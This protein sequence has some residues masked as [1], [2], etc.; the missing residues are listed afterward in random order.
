MKRKR[1]SQLLGLVLT[2]SMVF[3]MVGCG[4]QNKANNSEDASVQSNADTEKE[5][6][7]EK[8]AEA[9]SEEITY[10]LDTTDTLTIW[11]KNQI[12]PVASYADYTE[13][14]FHTGLA[15]NT[16]VEVEWT[17]P[18]EGAVADQAYNLLLTEDELPDIIFT[19]V[20]SGEAEQL[21]NDGVIYDL[22]E[23][24]PVYAPDY[25]ETIHK[26]EYVNVLQSLTTDS[27]KFYGVENFCETE[28]NVTYVGP[29]IRQD[30]LDE[31][32][33][34]T[35]VTMED[36]ENV[37]VAFK[38]NYGATLG[39]FTA[40]LNNIGIGSGTGAY[41]TFS[42]NF[43][44]DEN[45]KVQLAQAQQEWKEYMAYLHKW[46]DMGLIDKDSITMDDAAVRTKVLNGEIGVSFTA[47]S[48][49]TA[50]VG[51]AEAEGT[52]A[53]WV[54]FDYPRT[55]AGEPTCMIQ[56]RYSGSQGWCAMVTTSCPE[57]KLITA[58]K[59]LN[60]GYTEEG[61]M[62]WNYGT[63]GVSYYLDENGQPQWTELVTEDPDG[64][65]NARVKYNGTS[66]TGISIQLAHMVE[67]GFAEAAAEA[68]Y[69]WIDNTEASDHCLPMIS[70]T[71]EESAR[72]SDLMTSI[73][74]YVEET[75]MKF[76][77]GDV[78]LD[79]FDAFVEELNGMGL[80]E[81]LEIQQAAYDRFME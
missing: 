73:N 69:K 38:E 66:G 36:W 11:S 4:D 61:L 14:P 35:P 79:D 75:G 2:F 20:T 55:A 34:E 46:W 26:D 43:Y 63:E 22:T 12:K 54:G 41:G 77:T 76:M 64:A 5:E 27:G 6:E 45:G 13:S 71:D 18:A 24:L 57:D 78:S 40:R 67:I 39:F 65:S 23:Y 29:V 19:N 49:L 60:Y 52:G 80:E 50:W 37:L 1:I 28:Y 68:V 74:T 81:A 32:G 44:V 30:W 53:N 48:Q 21:I 15:E 7:S 9:V 10:P 17:Y 47:C 33:L 3:G 16:G 8:E 70:M 25:W 51:D 56:A 31:L 62:Y 59:W 42:T 72:Y 58:L